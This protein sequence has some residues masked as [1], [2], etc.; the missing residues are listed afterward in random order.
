MR[1]LIEW[2]VALALVGSVIWAGLPFVR[3]LAPLPAGTFTLV[4]STF[5][6]LPSGVPT[7]AQSVS[8]LI[9]ADGIELRLGMR[10]AEVRSRQMIRLTA[11]TPA[12][13]P[14]ILGERTTLPFRSGQSRFWVVL[15]HTDTGRQ[16]EVTAIYVR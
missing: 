8:F 4:E 10:E 12:S 14:G 3:G 15:D 6:A 2:M 7:G 13:E 1:S 16:R 5:P 11:G 9:L